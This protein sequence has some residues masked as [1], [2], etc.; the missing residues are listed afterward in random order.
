MAVSMPTMDRLGSEHGTGKSRKITFADT[1]SLF[2]LLVTPVRGAQCRITGPSDAGRPTKILIKRAHE[3]EPHGTVTLSR[4]A[5]RT[6]A[7]TTRSATVTETHATT[8]PPA[9]SAT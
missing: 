5:V 3:G 4:T 8:K 9:M 6:I 2:G 1:D 7:R